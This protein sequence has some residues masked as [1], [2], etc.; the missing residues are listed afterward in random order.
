MTHDT[1]TLERTLGHVLTAGTRIS[2]ALLG[3]GLLASFL[4]PGP[5][6]SQLL[7]VGLWVLLL[8][9]VARVLVSVVGFIA[10]RD[11]PF[12]LYTAIVLSLLVTSFIAAFGS[13]L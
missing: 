5:T 13:R 6:A 9:P 1:D 4:H 12:T 7:R 2:M 8:T 11:W 10:Q 3:A